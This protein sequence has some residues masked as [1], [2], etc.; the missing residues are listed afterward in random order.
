MIVVR[1]RAAMIV[2]RE[3]A[4]MIVVRES[5]HDCSGREQP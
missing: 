1:E 3:R 5:S 4:A 2:V